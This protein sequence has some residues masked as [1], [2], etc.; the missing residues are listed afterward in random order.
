MD[1]STGL[2]A[3]IWI[4]VQVERATTRTLSTLLTSPMVCMDETI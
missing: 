4:R 3:Q 1:T 2:P